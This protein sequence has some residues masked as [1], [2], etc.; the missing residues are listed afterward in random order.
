[1]SADFRLLHIVVVE[2]NLADVLLVGE[3]LNEMGMP[4]EI[5]HYKDGA[6]AINGLKQISEGAVP[7]DLFLLDINMPKATGLEVLAKIKSDPKLKGIPVAI[8][9]S[10]VAPNEKV[11]A[12]QLGADRFIRKPSDLYEFLAEVGTTLK[13]LMSETP[14]S[15]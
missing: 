9:T 10:S 1:M 5:I 8:L 4:H 11:R 7:A 2:D 15:P 14:K 12:E 13:N 6:E 3:C